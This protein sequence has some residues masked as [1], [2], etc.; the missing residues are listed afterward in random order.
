MSD[1]TN[2]DNETP[3]LPLEAKIIA[4][5]RDWF[6]RATPPLLAETHVSATIEIR[7]GEVGRTDSGEDWLA[8]GITE[9]L[10]GPFFDD[11]SGGVVMGPAR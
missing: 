9:K 1:Q 6:A 3:V 7:I 10:E 11:D 8:L 2:P 4:R 5:V